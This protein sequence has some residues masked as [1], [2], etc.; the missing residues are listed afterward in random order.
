LQERG[1]GV[2]FAFGL[3]LLLPLGLV[4]LLPLGFVFLPFGRGPVRLAVLAA[5]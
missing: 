4:L 5:Q 1:F 3:V 2:A